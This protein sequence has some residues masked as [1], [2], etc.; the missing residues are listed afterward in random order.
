[1]QIAAVRWLA[2]W[3]ALLLATPVAAQRDATVEKPAPEQ[4]APE[5]PAAA[6]PAG[7]A[8]TESSSFSKWLNGF[9]NGDFSLGSSLLGTSER[10]LKIPKARPDPGDPGGVRPD[11]GD[12]LN[13]K[14]TPQPGTPPK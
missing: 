12:P 14:P 11:P 4:P 8:A 7:A 6:K 2:P 3:A 9:V 10:S 1:M 13:P 5:K